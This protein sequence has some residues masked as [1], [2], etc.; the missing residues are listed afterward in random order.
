VRT[1]TSTVIA[2]AMAVGAI[3]PA[4][5]DE[6][7][8]IRHQV[9][10]PGSGVFHTC[11]DGG[12]ITWSGVSHRDYTEWY[13]HGAKVREHRHISFDATL[14]LDGQ[15]VPY[16]GIW[17]RDQDFE[18]G[19][20]RITGGQFRVLFPTGPVLVGAGMRSQGNEFV[21]TGDRFLQDLCSRM[22]G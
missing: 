8:I 12:I 5:A 1:L 6:V 18:T 13:R 7:D 4:S 10:V 15:S 22:G 17:N 20:V 14:T 16:T 9:D 2:L 21:G 11:E 19:K 3:A